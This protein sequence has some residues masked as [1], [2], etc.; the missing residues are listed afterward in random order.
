MF[1]NILTI[2]SI[3][4]IFGF[5]CAVTILSHKK[6]VNVVFLLITIVSFCGIWVSGIMLLQ[7]IDPMSSEKITNDQNDVVA[8]TG[9]SEEDWNNVPITPEIPEHDHIGTAT[10][11]L[12][13]TDG[14]DISETYYVEATDKDTYKFC[15]FHEDGQHIIKKE[16]PINIV[17]CEFSNDNLPHRV[18]VMI[19]D[20]KPV[21]YTLYLPEDSN[22]IQ[23]DTDGR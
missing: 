13:V 14:A 10:L 17:Q 1:F 12:Y 7:R 21:F 3:S 6:T 2:I 16:V 18:E 11:S 9:N 4:A 5:A 15:Y 20:D 19:Q 22:T 8:E 23:F